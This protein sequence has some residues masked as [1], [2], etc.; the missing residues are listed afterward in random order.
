MKRIREFDVLKGLCITAVILIHVTS[1]GVGTFDPTSTSYFVYLILNRLSQFAVPTFIFASCVLISYIHRDDF[2][3]I[4]AGGLKAFYTKRFVRIIPPY[5]IW[6]LVY[7]VVRHIESNGSVVLNL[8][9]Y[10]NLLLKSD[11]YYHLYFV[12]LILQVYIFLPFIMY[13]VS[14]L[15]IK[16]HYVLS[17][18]VGMQVA[19]YYFYE[20][21]LTHYFPRGTRLMIWYLVFILI[22]VWIG[23]N[24]EEYCKRE[25]HVT[26]FLPAALISGV[27]Y[28]YFYHLSNISRHVPLG[29]L[30]L[31][32]YIYAFSMPLLLLYVSKKVNIRF[33]ERAGQLSFG[34][35]LMHPL[36][37][38]I[39]YRMN[40]TVNV[41]LYDIL[42]FFIIYSL[43]YTITKWLNATPWGKYIVG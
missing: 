23:D 25:K 42:S 6:T 3:T 29:R 30:N 11:G 28:T 40:T 18:S 14:H 33:F 38:F 22:G 37:L 27:L 32:W 24:Y 16:F 10:F 4:T 34:I 7:L 31:V 15:N 9:N 8:G 19:C 13:G 39:M 20:S 41:I 43:S 12:I 26:I 35:F 21:Y 36:F 2:R 17:L 5:L 1:H